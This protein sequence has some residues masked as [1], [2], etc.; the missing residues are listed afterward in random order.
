MKPVFIGDLTSPETVFEE[1]G[2]ED[3]TGI[4]ILFVAYDLYRDLEGKIFVL[5]EKDGKLHEVNG[6]HWSY[7]GLL[8]EWEPEETT[9]ED[10]RYRLIE[11]KMGLEYYLYGDER[12]HDVYNTALLKFLKELEEEK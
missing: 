10:L 1:F 12:N 5:F 8:G 7:P 6:H 2:V 3:K 11:G 9:I 4:N